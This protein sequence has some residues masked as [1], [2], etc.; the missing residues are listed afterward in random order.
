M[1]E[2][3]QAVRYTAKIDPPAFVRWLVPGLDP[4]YAFRTWLD[5]RTIAFPGEGDRTCDTVAE[6]VR[7]TGPG[8][9][10]ALV[11][12]FQSEPDPEMLDRL[13]EYVARLPLRRRIPWPCLGPVPRTAACGSR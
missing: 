9:R 13:L 3:D 11:T 6:L 12:E 2:L 10:V 5:T 8:P 4:A 7:R 1:N